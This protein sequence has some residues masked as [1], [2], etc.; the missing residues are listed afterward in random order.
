MN[1]NNPDCEIKH[2]TSQRPSAK[3]A[4]KYINGT[5][6]FGDWNTEYIS[7][8]DRHTYTL[9]LT[10]QS[11]NLKDM[12]MHWCNPTWVTEQS[13]AYI[14]GLT[15]CTP[16]RIL[17]FVQVLKTWKPHLPNQ[18]SRGWQAKVLYSSPRFIK[19]HNSSQNFS[20]YAIQPSYFFFFIAL[21][22][23]DQ[24]FSIKREMCL[25]QIPTLD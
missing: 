5:Y 1:I 14:C 23:I 3:Q 4:K 6:V 13:C 16:I 7:S 17:V 22:T 20:A 8:Y 18:L 10:P 2:W 9:S 15:E 21:F 24:A 25:M 11:R 19:H 12:K